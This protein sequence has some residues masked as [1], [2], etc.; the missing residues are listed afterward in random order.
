MAVGERLQG[1]GKKSGI[2]EVTPRHRAYRARMHSSR[3]PFNR[4]TLA[5]AVAAAA[6][7]ITGCG[8]DGTADSSSTTDA[9]AS[10]SSDSTTTAAS[11][12]AKVNA[13][14]ATVEELAA[15]FDAAGVPN[16]Q[17]WAREVD[18]YRPY[19]DDGWDHLRQ[20]LSKYN[21][22]QATF[23]KIVGTLEL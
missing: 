2:C 1:L 6:L 21:I 17:Q 12:A 9:P 8:D 7:L 19:T 5:G 3:T 23:D 14:D 13:N 11:G 10:S 16:S 18:E 22:D 4:T 20:E 15:A